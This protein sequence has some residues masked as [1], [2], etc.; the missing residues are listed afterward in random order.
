ME[1]AQA[2]K[3][4][5]ILRFIGR[6]WYWFFFI[7]FIIPDFVSSVKIALESKNYLYPL[8]QL[9]SKVLASD[10]RTYEIVQGLIQD[11]VKIIGMENPGPSETWL[12]IIYGW[13]IFW[14]VIYELVGNLWIMFL[15]FVVI[16]KIANKW[17]ATSEVKNFFWSF[18]IFLLILFIVNSIVL[19]YKISMGT[20]SLNFAEGTS[21]V[22]GYLSVFK[23]ILPFHG[24]GSLI[25]YIL[26]LLF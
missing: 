19:V 3:W 11:P 13:K 10:T 4:I 5:V 15:P 16:F 2:N 7:L 17:D 22:I 18:I 25:K 24:I 12:T 14:N 8:F 23:R 20:I 9:F 1:V 21:E 26:S 6:N